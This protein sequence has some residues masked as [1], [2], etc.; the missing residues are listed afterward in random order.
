MSDSAANAAAHPDAA[1]GVWPS[2]AY[3]RYVGWLRAAIGEALYF[4]EAHIGAVNAAVHVQDEPLELLAVVDFPKPDPQRRLYPHVL[5]LA[6]GRGLNLGRIARVSRGSAFQP[7]PEDILYEEFYLLDSL[8]YRPRQL[9]RSQAHEI[10]RRQLA[11]GLGY[12]AAS[13]LIAAESKDPE[14]Q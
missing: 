5:L 3:Q 6:D 12:E 14:K 8:L 2:P 7:R 1:A 9:S 10:T 11:S 4:V 13:A